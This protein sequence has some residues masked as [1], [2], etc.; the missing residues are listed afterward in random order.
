M[1]ARKVCTPEPAAVCAATAQNLGC[2]PHKASDQLDAAAL[3]LS[4]CQ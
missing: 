4:C 3:A 2:L 1:Q